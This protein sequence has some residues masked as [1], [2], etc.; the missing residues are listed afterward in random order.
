MLHHLIGNL[1]YLSLHVKKKMPNK[2][3][4]ATVNV[5]NS[6]WPANLGFLNNLGFL[7]KENN[8]PLAE[9]MLCFN[10]DHI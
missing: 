4:T 10:W 1:D 6:S 8:D 2:K 9:Y 5:Q 7:E 3:K